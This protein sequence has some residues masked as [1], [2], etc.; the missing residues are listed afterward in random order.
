[1]VN[2]FIKFSLIIIFSAMLFECSFDDKT[3]IWD[4]NKKIKERSVK[5]I[6][7]SDSQSLIDAELNPDLEINLNF[8]PIKNNNWLM[9][10]KNYA[11]S[12]NHLKFDG[13]LQKFS[14]L[15]FEKI[16]NKFIKENPLIIKENYLITVDGEGS[17]LK[18]VNNKIQW[19]RNIYSKKEKKKIDNISL[20]LFKEKLYAIDNLGK[21]YVLDVNTGRTIWI[22][23]HKALFNSQIKVLKNKIFAVDSDN[24]INCFSIDNGKI[25]WSFTTNPSFIKTTKKLSIVII[26]DS[27]IFSNTSGDISNVNINTGEL[28]WFLPTENTLVKH[29]TN[30]L[31]T[32][33]IVFFKKDLF[34]SNNFSKL[35]SL[36][37]KSGIL[38]W[39]LNVNSN[40]RPVISNNYLFTISQ[41]GYL[42]VVDIVKGKIIRANNILKKFQLKQ[43]KK[44]VIQGFL[45]A[46]GKV[47]VTTNIGYII[48]CSANTGKVQNVSKIG[49]FQLSEP[50]IGGNKLHV[51]TNKSV[52]VFN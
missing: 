22:K 12:V 29:E 48:I 51:L 38:N 1:M 31:E 49:N 19:N 2:K 39:I 52:L 37:K 7:L 34:F 14:K 8:E 4:N 36:D 46:S 9:S 25:L 41:D 35:F 44:L 45:V 17:I 26:Q 42:I 21:Y 3:G 16:E 32:S 5:L 47:Y 50:L 30:F 24:V 18:F 28:N 11:N 40:L 13:N 10:G 43:K 23:Q 27:V 15:K 6:K 33:D 20:T